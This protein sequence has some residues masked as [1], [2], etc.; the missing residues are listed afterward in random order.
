MSIVDRFRQKKF[1]SSALTVTTLAIG[2]ML[3]TLI[4]TGV[5]A[6]KSDKPVT[7]ATPLVVPSPT[8]LATTSPRSSR[9]WSRPLFMSAR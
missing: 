4:N 6:D 2:M 1:L 9:R 8:Q 5:L 7:D 3:G